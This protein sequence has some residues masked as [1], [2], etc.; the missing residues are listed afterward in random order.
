MFNKTH[1]F[2]FLVGRIDTRGL[3]T[4]AA[5]GIA[6][7]CLVLFVLLVL[8]VIFCYRK[9]RQ[10]RETQ[11]TNQNQHYIAS[12]VSTI[13]YGDDSSQRPLQ[14]SSRNTTPRYYSTL[15]YNNNQIQQLRHAFYTSF[16]FPVNRFPI[17]LKN[18]EM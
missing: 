16:V 12:D 15:A 13:S 9:K 14:G 7:A 8:N 6:L 5:V 10:Q 3:G 2:L 18:N 17:V 11:A 1:E 4:S